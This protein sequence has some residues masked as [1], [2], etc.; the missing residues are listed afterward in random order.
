ML[1]SALMSPESAKQQN[2]PTIA[3]RFRDMDSR[4]DQQVFLDLEELLAGQGFVLAHE[5]Q[6]SEI[7]FDQSLFTRSENFSRVM[8]MLDSGVPITISKAQHANMC[9]MSSG[10]GFR[11]AMTE[12]FSGKDVGGA[13]KVVM[14]FHGS[15]LDS[16]STIP[17][18]DELWVTKPETAA[19]SLSG[20]GVVTHDDI[21]MLSFRFPIR[22][23]PE[24]L[25]TEDEVDRLE[26]SGIDFIVRHY[27]VDK[28]TATH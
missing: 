12:G 23:F 22:F 18:D 16:Y 3:E 9:R 25:L 21:V 6:L 17:K 13:V 26:T 10:A 24:H 28:K 19:V 1:Q 14:T 20:S 7:L 5:W 4:V 15:E 11:T 8:D 27:V 2:K